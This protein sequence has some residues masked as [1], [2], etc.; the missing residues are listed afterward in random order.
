M[1]LFHCETTVI[2]VRVARIGL[3]AG[4]TTCTITSRVLA[5]SMR[6]AFSRSLGIERKYSRSRKIAYGEPNRNGSTNAQNVLRRPTSAIIRYSGTTVT[7]A[8]T[9]RVAR[10]TQKTASR[11]G[12][13]SRAKA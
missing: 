5:P 3:L 1:K 7:V 2:S 8:G 6:A 10:Y 9:I 11:P 12:N 4:N 13:S